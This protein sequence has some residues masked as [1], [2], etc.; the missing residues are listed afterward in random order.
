M[1]AC[2]TVSTQ[3]MSFSRDLQGDISEEFLE[4]YTWIVN[5]FQSLIGGR[6][7]HCQGGNGVVLSSGDRPLHTQ[8]CAGSYTQPAAGE[9]CSS[10]L[11]TSPNRK[12]KLQ[13]AQVSSGDSEII[14][15]KRPRL[16]FLSVLKNTISYAASFLK[17]PTQFS[18]I[19]LKL[20]RSNYT[21]RHCNKQVKPY[22]GLDRKRNMETAQRSKKLFES[23]IFDV[24]EDFSYKTL[25]CYVKPI[26]PQRMSVKYRSLQDHQFP[27]RKCVKDN[28]LTHARLSDPS[29]TF[30]KL[31]LTVDEDVQKEEREKYQQLL[32]LVK[33]GYQRKSGSSEKSHSCRS[34]ALPGRTHHEAK[35]SGAKQNHVVVVGRPLQTN[36]TD[37]SSRVASCLSFTNDPVSSGK[38]NAIV[39]GRHEQSSDKGKRII[40]K[41]MEK[42]IKH[43]LGH[44]DPD[45]ILSSAFKLNITRQDFWTLKNKHWLN[46]EIINFYMNLLVKRNKENGFPKLHVFSTFFYPKL[47][48]GGYQAVRRWTKDV[49]LFEKDIILVPVH[50]DVHWSLLVCDLRKKTIKYYDSIGREGY[51]ICQEFLK[52]LQEEHKAK[53]NQS[54]DNTRWKLHS[55]KPQEIPQQMNGSDC[56]VFVCKYA[57]YISQDKPITFTQSHMP[58]FRQKMVWEILHQKLL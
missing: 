30:K 33:G 56:G 29:K 18:E 12:R 58:D 7:Q 41:E 28:R 22:V 5:S 14:P 13:R 53:R 17:F 9:P 35:T 43:V 55:M 25:P 10:N 48:S 51:S 19:Y 6:A 50:L 20:F 39:E 45:D 32:E 44:G 11:I 57:D 49:H 8:A 26:D 16:D 24:D 15:A 38:E 31:T 4:M 27:W 40:T 37:L 23:R 42:E 36:E 46:D 21:N 1:A 2:E 3:M 47:L 34:L 54:L 52:Y